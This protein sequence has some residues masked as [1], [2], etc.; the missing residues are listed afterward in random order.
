MFK[1]KGLE[2][3]ITK[4]KK[5]G[6]ETNEDE[7]LFNLETN[8]VPLA[9]ALA[10]VKTGAL[11][12]SIDVDKVGPNRC[13]LHDGVPY[14]KYQELGFVHEKTGQFIRNPFMEPALEAT[15]PDIEKR[16]GKKIIV[17]WR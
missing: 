16:I 5:L 9:K 14:G 3:I 10:P 6:K 2:D 11:R 15:I 13:L 8:T 4:I 7:L 12:D 17:E 1:M